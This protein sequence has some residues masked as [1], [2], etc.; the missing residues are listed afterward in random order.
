MLI[1]DVSGEA[2]RIDAG[3][4]LG[5]GEHVDLAMRLLERLGDA[6]RGEAL[7]PGQHV[8][9]VRLHRMPEPDTGVCVGGERLA[10]HVDERVVLRQRRHPRLPARN[11]PDQPARKIGDQRLVEIAGAPD[12]DRP[13]AVAEIEPFEAQALRGQ[14]LADL[15]R[16]RLEHLQSVGVKGLHRG[17]RPA[18]RLAVGVAPRGLQRVCIG[19][20]EHGGRRPDRDLE[21]AVGARIRNPAG[22]SPRARPPTCR[23]PPRAPS[24]PS[25][26]S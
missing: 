3:L 20:G 17:G 23:A 25:R 21:R 6:E 19:D 5:V 26:R 18:Q 9:G 7:A 16:T 2:V 1:D 15:L 11:R 13:F 8:G 10:G 24:A 22:R 14:G 4:A 12:I